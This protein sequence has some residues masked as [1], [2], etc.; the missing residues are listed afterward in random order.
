VSEWR[1]IETAPKDG[2]DILL[3]HRNGT[4]MIVAFWDDE[5]TEMA[6]WQTADGMAYHER[7]PGYWRPLPELPK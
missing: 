5:G 1:P 6:R 4:S 7:W 3:V 2:N